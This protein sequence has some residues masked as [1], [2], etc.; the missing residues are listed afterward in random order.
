MA[1]VYRKYCIEFG[2][3][4]ILI[5]SIFILTMLLKVKE[6]YNGDNRAI[7]R[8]ISIVEND[9]DEAD[10]LLAEL[11]SHT[12]GAYRLGITGPPGA[13]K[14]TLVD[15]LTRL[16]RED[17]KSVGVVAVD[18]TSPFT[19]GALL[20]DRLRLQ[21]LSLNKDVF[22]RSVASRGST[23]GIS[24]TTNEVVDILDSS[25]KEVIMIE[26]VGVGQ[27]E[28][29]VAEASDTTLVVIVPDS[30]DE[31]QAMKAGLMEIADI[32]VLNKSDHYGADIA[33]SGLQAMLQLREENAW[34]PLII[35]T[36]ALK[37]EGI[38][39]LMKAI[40][41]HEDWLKSENR[42]SERRKHRL[43]ERVKDIIAD[44]LDKKFWTKDKLKF[45]YN[46]INESENGTITPYTLVEEL[47]NLK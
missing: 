33:Y 4:R 22:F 36:S 28:L 23:G 25:G 19:G 27:S 34:T 46:K 6:I 32:F 2:L 43:N 17:G 42:L 5:Q 20:G 45:L 44:D 41:E 21:E 38:D 1:N 12:G 39:D 14:S 16:F 9:N 10:S 18:P 29:D 13:G 15:N 35:K 40:H 24:K 8:A 11:Y 26:T 31:I 30:G 37:N 3:R 47:K 7:A